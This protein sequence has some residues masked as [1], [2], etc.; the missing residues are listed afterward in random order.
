[1]L[2][3]FLFFEPRAKPEQLADALSFSTLFGIFTRLLLC[4]R[5]VS[6]GGSQKWTRVMLKVSGE[7]LAGENGFGI[8]PD[9]VHRIARQVAEASMAGV[10]VAVVVG[11]GN[12]FRGAQHEGKGLDRASADYMG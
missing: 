12:F 3:A 10:Q 2:F 7:A 11:G 1:L 9:V 5:R 4:H 6:V 8:D